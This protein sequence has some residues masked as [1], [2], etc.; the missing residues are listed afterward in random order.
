MMKTQ[1]MGRIKYLLT[2]CIFAT[3]ILA[4]A[5]GT[6]TPVVTPGGTVL[7]KQ[8]WLVPVLP[9]SISFCGEPAP[10][11]DQ[12]IAEQLEREVLYNYYQ[13]NQILYVIKLSRRY[14][15]LIEARL[16][17]NGVPSDLKYLCIAESNLQNAIS[18]AGAVG[19]WQFMRGTAPG[20]GLEVSAEVDERY[21]IEKSTDAA[22]KYL[23]AAYNKF[24]SW[25][26]AAASYNC[27]QGGYN[28]RARFQGTNHYYDLVL[29]EET[30]R[31]VFR[32]LTFKYFLENANALGFVVNEGEGY[33]PISYKRVKVSGSVA[34]L[35][36]FAVKQGVS[37][38]TLV[39][40][41]PWIRGRAL[42]NPKKKTYE[43][44]IPQ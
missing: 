26:A 33:E 42:S 18:K 21:H 22:C 30:S 44:L 27:G 25:T 23:K 4:V 9:D 19:F 6:R 38:K 2:G 41:N 5:G 12:F 8:E 34:N 35:N 40:H 15:P 7:A 32:I 14:F 36:D 29:P 1:G 10:M 13:P 43:F 37:F 11:N 31:Y 3:V 20:F 24:G 39:D 28:S 17:A 16:A